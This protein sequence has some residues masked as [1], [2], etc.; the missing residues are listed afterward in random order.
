M[1]SFEYLSR[2]YNS[3][4]VIRQKTQGKIEG[5]PATQLNDQRATTLAEI[6]TGSWIVPYVVDG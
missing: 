5:W 6:Y 1:Y 2:T 3:V 4:E